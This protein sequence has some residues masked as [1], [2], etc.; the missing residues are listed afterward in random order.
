LGIREGWRRRRRRRRKV[1]SWRRIMMQ[2]RHETLTDTGSRVGHLDDHGRDTDGASEEHI[3]A[4]ASFIFE[5]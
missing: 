4:S 1:Y 3:C 5:L 2:H